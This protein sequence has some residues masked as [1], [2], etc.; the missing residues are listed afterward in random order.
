MNRTC[1]RYGAVRAALAASCLVGC[2][3]DVDTPAGRAEQGLSAAKLEDFESYAP[4][5]LG[6]PWV[7]TGAGTSTVSVA[8]TSDHGQVGLRHG[9]TGPDYVI[10]SLD[11]SSSDPV[12]HAEVAV[13]PAAGASFI[14]SLHGAGGSIGARRIRLQRVAGSNMLAANTTGFDAG[15][16]HDDYGLC[17]H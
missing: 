8:S 12:M 9:G 16:D 13:N 14:F 6:A 7:L 15:A 1:V 4:G 10:A 17:G 3:V 5:P 11:A 2:A